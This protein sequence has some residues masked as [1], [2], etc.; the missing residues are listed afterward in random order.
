VI[1]LVEDCPHTPPAQRSGQSKK[2]KRKYQRASIRYELKSPGNLKCPGEQTKKK[3][4]FM[5]NENSVKFRTAEKK[6]GERRKKEIKKEKKK[7]RAERS[8]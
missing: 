8:G 2:R 3:K 6:R 4:G 5:N 7:D 1:Y